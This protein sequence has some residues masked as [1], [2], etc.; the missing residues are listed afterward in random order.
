LATPLNAREPCCINILPA[1]LL[2]SSS[3]TVVRDRARQIAWSV[4]ARPLPT[5]Q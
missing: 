1:S 5:R 2:S 4:G 3:A